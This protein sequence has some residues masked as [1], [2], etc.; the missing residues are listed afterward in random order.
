MANQYTMH[1]LADYNAAYLLSK[2]TGRAWSLFMKYYL[3]SSLIMILALG[4]QWLEGV[5]IWGILTCFLISFFTYGISRGPPKPMI[6]PSIIFFLGALGIVYSLNS[7]QCLI[8]GSAEVSE[9]SEASE[10]SEEAVK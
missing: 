6:V 9:A 5:K 3:F 1:P 10:V 2:T 4:Q 8:F 7:V